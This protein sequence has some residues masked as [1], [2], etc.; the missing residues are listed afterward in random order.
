MIRPVDRRLLRFLAAQPAPTP[1]ANVAHALGF[2]V[3]ALAGVVGPLNKGCVTAGF[4]VPVVSQTVT[5]TTPDGRRRVRMLSIPTGLA[6]VVR[7]NDSGEDEPETRSGSV[8]RV[9]ESSGER[10]TRTGEGVDG[11]VGLYADAAGDGV[12]FLVARTADRMVVPDRVDGSEL[13]ADRAFALFPRRACGASVATVGGEGV[14]WSE[15][16]AVDTDGD[17]TVV[18]GRAEIDVAFGGALAETGDASASSAWSVGAVVAAAAESL[19]GLL[20]LDERERSASVAE[21]LRSLIAVRADRFAGVGAAGHDAGPSAHNAWFPCRRVSLS[22]SCA[23]WSVGRGEIDRGGLAATY[24]LLGGQVRVAGDADSSTF[25][26][27]RQRSRS[28]AMST[29]RDGD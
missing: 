20:G 1:A 11:C 12:M 16:S 3:A 2:D 21:L 18:A 5:T 6:E 7:S 14:A 22:A 25:K 8:P 29:A 26:G 19:S 28:P 10:A 23:D 27:V 9:V 13:S 17:G 15:L 24:A 4:P